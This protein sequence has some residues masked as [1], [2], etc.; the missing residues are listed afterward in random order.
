MQLNGQTFTYG[1]FLEWSH[2]LTQEGQTSGP[3]QEEPMIEYTALNHHRMERIHKRHEVNEDLKVVI[4]NL[5]NPQQWIVLTETW[6]GDSAQNLPII[7]KAA[8]YAGN[9]IQLTI[10]QRDQNLHLIDQY[11]PEIGQ[12]IPR[13]LVFDDQD[14]F[15]THWGARPKPAQAFIDKWKADPENVSKKEVQ[16]EMQLWY[17]KNKQQALQ[18]ELM[19]LLKRTQKGQLTE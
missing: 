4:D 1:E 17:A 5:A 16:K 3:K 6:C 8:E 15:L 19:T 18:E 10:A 9:K 7:G 13:L 14:R 2:K 11:I 12:G